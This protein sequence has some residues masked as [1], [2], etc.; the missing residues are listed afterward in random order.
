MV[1]AGAVSDFASASVRTS[2]RQSVADAANV[3]LAAVELT[4]TSASVRLQFTIAFDSVTAASVGVSELRTEPATPEKASVLLSTAAVTVVVDTVEALPE[5]PSPEAPPLPSPPLPPPPTVVVTTSPSPA[6]PPSPASPP[7]LP[8]PPAYV[9]PAT[10]NPGWAALPASTSGV[11]ITLSF[12]IHN[13]AARPVARTYDGH[14]WEA[15]DASPFP[16]AA[17]VHPTTYAIGTYDPTTSI[18]QFDACAPAGSH[19]E[20]LIPVG[21]GCV[22]YCYYR[23]DRYSTTTPADATQRAASRFLLQATFGPT[24]AMLAGSLGSDMSAPSVR[25]WIATQISLPVT[26]L[27]AYMRRATNPRIRQN[28]EGTLVSL[29]PR[30]LDEARPATALA[31]VPPPPHVSPTPPQPR[32]LPAHRKSR[33]P[34]GGSHTPRVLSGLSL[35]PICVQLG[36]RGLDRAD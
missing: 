26:T 21:A 2:L 25:A 10:L 12:V 32:C 8:A 5:I 17:A 1:V 33:V 13:G 6:P 16:P 4:V 7:P 19:C 22:G 9:Y 24:R 34:A 23:L 30:S 11:L 18:D 28:L 35:A 3:P 20:V 29:C 27:R 14:G 15:L 31:P 36:G